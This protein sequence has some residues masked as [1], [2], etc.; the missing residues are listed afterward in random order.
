MRRVA[1]PTAFPALAILV[2]AMVSGCSRVSPVAPSG[3]TLSLSANPSFISSA[4]GTSTITA[5]VFRPNGQ[6]ALS[7]TVVRFQADIATITS[8]ATTDSS[9]IATAILHAD[10]VL[11][12]ATVSATT[13]TA[14]T[15]TML[16]VNIGPTAPLAAFLSL[17]ADP[18][19][20]LG[21]GGKVKLTAVV[22]D[23]AGNPVANAGVVFSSPVGVLRSGG[24][25]VT[26]NSN[27]VATDQ[28]TVTQQ[29]LSNQAGT[30]TVTASTIGAS[31]AVN[32]TFAV[33]VN[34]GLPI[35][36]F[37][38][39]AVPA[40]LGIQFINQST[41]TSGLMY[42][43]EFGDGTSSTDQSPLHNYT[44]PGTFQVLLVVTNI[45]GLSDTAIKS[46]TVS[47]TAAP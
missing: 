7:G 30:F 13:G 32:S 34:T 1:L 8:E 46:V 26:T 31:G 17:Q 38:T 47:T 36:A 2:L 21:A 9:G 10:G 5:L 19:S 40:T 44:A 24:A 25:I 18:P 29:D 23:A 11:G 3:S 6:P 22:R 42:N 37:T 4:S 16:T 28:L 14:T 20:I 12:K 43:W 27:G 35:A 45:Q 15:A 41:P 39:V 33:T